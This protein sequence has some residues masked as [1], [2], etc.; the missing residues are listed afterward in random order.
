MSGEARIAPPQPLVRRSFDASEIN[1]ILN[2]PSVWSMISIPGLDHVDVTEIVADPR[3]VLLMADGGGIIFAQFEP[4]IYE[5]HTNFIE[6]KRG[7]NAIRASLAA[8]RWMFMHTDCMTL[9]TRV[10]EFNKAAERFCQIVGATK[11]F[12]RKAVWPTTDGMADLSFWALRYDDW[13]RKTDELMNVGRAFHERLEQEYK[14]L[15]QIEPNHADDPAHDRHV[16]A[17]VAMI[18]SGQP[19]KG[20]VLYNRW[21]KFAGY[22]PIQP[23]A[24]DPFVIDIGNALLQVFPEL[25]DF[26]VIKCR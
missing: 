14:R 25:Q 22:G 12:E 2:D 20:I 1:P 9:L 26:R 6:G 23:I 21:A 19:E 18:Y 15:G 13:V 5:V 8:Y 24:R 11:E 16:G 17:C 4:G 10:P 7:R 3:N